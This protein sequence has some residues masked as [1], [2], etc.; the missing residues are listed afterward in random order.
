MR[1]AIG[2]SFFGHGL[3]RLPKIRTF[4]DGIVEM[5]Q[6]AM[7]PLVLVRYFTL[8]LPVVEFSVGLLILV[9]LF[10][11]QALAAGAVVMLFLI[12]GTTLIE[13]WGGIPSQ[14]I[15]AFFFAVLISHLQHNS[16]ALDHV[17]RPRA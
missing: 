1:L 10:T 2:M 6:D 16:R 13:N 4:S 8:V 14:L 3:V 17:L 11:R 15:H 9:G 5:F 7:I 12:F